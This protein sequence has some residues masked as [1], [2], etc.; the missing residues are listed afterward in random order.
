IVAKVL[1]D[2]HCYIHSADQTAHDLIKPGRPAWSR[3]VAHFGAGILNSDRTINRRR[4]GKI[5]FSSETDRAFLNGLLHPLVLAKKKQSIRRLERLG[6]HK[7]FVSEAA[8][9]IESGFAPF[10]D[11]VV[12]VHCPEIV[13]VQRL[14]KR[15]G[16][17]RRA[18]WK[19]IRSQMQTAE[20]I[21]YAD[22]LI[23][24]SG[25]PAETKAQAERLYRSLLSDFRKKAGREKK[26]GSSG[27]SRVQRPRA[28]P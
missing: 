28:G 22:Y 2:H 11:R 20:K 7:I 12:V 1:S 26:G 15:E 14:M 3:I 21:R 8:L 17:S 16:I 25:T 19:K 13:Q 5:V 9:T 27:G 4:L 18:A 24:T 6:T 10:F 23:D